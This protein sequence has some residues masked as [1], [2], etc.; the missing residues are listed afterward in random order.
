MGWP[1]VLVVEVQGGKVLI[2]SVWHLL[3]LFDGC[4]SKSQQH[5]AAVTVAWRAAPAGAAA[6]AVRCRS[7][8]LIPSK[9]CCCACQCLLQLLLELLLQCLLLLPSQLC[10][11]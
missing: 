6:E 9:R 8:Q 1:G 2:S 11:S 10:W 5:A 7:C 3:L 4:D